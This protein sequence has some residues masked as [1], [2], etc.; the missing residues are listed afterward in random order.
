MDHFMTSLLKYP[1][2]C[3]RQLGI[4]KESHAAIGSSLLTRLI[5]AA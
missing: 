5:F 2:E 4:K 3:A 1:P